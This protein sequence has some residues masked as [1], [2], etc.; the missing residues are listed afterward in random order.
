[1]PINGPDC[2]APTTP[3]KEGQS[4]HI[5]CKAKMLIKKNKVSQVMFHDVHNYELIYS[6]PKTSLILQ[7]HRK[8]THRR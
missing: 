3:C 1:M 2:V 6:P 5:G 4:I 7:S 8:I